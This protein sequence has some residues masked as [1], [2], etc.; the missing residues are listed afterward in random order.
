MLTSFS[1]NLTIKLPL[2]ARKMRRQKLR[3]K[4]EAVHVFQNAQRLSDLPNQHAPNLPSGHQGLQ[5]LPLPVANPRGETGKPRANKQKLQEVPLNLP[6]HQQILP[7]R[8]FNCR[9]ILV[10]MC[11]QPVVQATLL[12]VAGVM[13]HHPLLLETKFLAHSH[14]QNGA[15]VVRVMD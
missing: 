12:L 10:D 6:L 9:R 5:S 2:N 7:P 4:V 15:L 11:H 8:K 3:L 1:E 13:Q 14:L